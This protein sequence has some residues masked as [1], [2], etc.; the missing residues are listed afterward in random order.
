M[1]IRRTELKDMTRVIELIELAKKYFKGANIDQWQNGYPNEESILDDIKN[2]ISYVVEEK[3]EIVGTAVISFDED[4]NY[5]E[6]EGQWISNESY[7]V[8]HRVAI[9]P[10]YKGLGIG[11]KIIEH[12]EN[13]A[14][15]KKINFLRI[16]THED[17]IS[18]R[19][20]IVKNK[21]N[22][23]GIIYVIDKMPRLAFEKKVGKGNEF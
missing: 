22:Y 11:S 7:G 23:C 17:N 1:E 8:L 4:P 21:F 18:M 19:K 5:K 9:D 13:E 15:K 16:D 12:A 14:I 6:I 10:S 2:D 3:N 20:L